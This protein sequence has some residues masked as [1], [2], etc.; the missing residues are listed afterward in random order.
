MTPGPYPSSCPVAGG[1]L[2]DI[3]YVAGATCGRHG[4]S[5]GQ[6]RRAR[7]NH[8]K[9]PF[10][11]LRPWAMNLELEKGRHSHTIVKARE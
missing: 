4:L 5:L 11:Y 3:G 9:Y 2:T 6:G 7:L 8:A 1:G 10:P